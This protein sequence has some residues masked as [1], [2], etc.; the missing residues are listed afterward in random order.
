MLQQHRCP[1]G[2]RGP[3]K[4]I[5][6]MSASEELETGRESL[7]L[8]GEFLGVTAMACYSAPWFLQIVLLILIGSTFISKVRANS[9]QT[10]KLVEEME[11]EFNDD[12]EQDHILQDFNRLFFG[13]TVAKRNLTAYCT[14]LS[15]YVITFAYAVSNTVEQTRPW[16]EKW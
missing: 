11:Q 3:T 14:G 10:R 12:H 6:R 15:I 1:R 13:L 7:N 4:S 16:W 9:Q 5:P 2:P 8:Q